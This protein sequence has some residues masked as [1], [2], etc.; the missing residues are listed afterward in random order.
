[1]RRSGSAVTDAQ[2]GRLMEEMSKYGRVGDAAMKAGMDRKAAG[3]YVDEGRLPSEVNRSRVH[4]GPSCVDV[5]G[6]TMNDP[7]SDAP[8]PTCTFPIPLTGPAA[9]AHTSGPQ[10]RAH[11]GASAAS[12]TRTRCR[13]GCA[14]HAT[15][16]QD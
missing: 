12:G 14:L 10:R 7:P 4:R 6:S 1:M 11:P 8:R 15:P 3:R 16:E 9:F 2:V 5:H 13:G